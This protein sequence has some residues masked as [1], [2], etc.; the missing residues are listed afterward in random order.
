VVG[1]RQPLVEPDLLAA[2]DALR[3]QSAHALAGAV[4]IAAGSILFPLLMRP[5][6]ADVLNPLFDLLALASPVAGWFV[7]VWYQN[8]AWR[9]RR[10]RPSATA[11]PTGL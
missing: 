3:A 10:G 1:R 9:V 2:D 8:R 4:I 5:G 11:A 6:G 7:G